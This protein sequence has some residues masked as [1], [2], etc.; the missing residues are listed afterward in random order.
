M[1]CVLVKLMQLLENET[2]DLVCILLVHVHFRYI[3]V[4]KLIPLAR[5]ERW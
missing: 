1:A 3:V 5:R 4:I 2:F